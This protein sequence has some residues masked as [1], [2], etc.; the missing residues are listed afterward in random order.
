M[1]PTRI[2]LV[3]HGQTA[4]FMTGA[5]NALTEPGRDQ[6]SALGRYWAQRGF[7]PDVVLCGPQPRHRETLQLARAAAE[8]HGAPWPDPR[9]HPGFDEHDGPAVALAGLPALVERGEPLARRLAAGD[10]LDGRERARLFR[11][12]MVGWLQGEIDA[13]GTESFQA[14]RVRVGAAL[15]DALG[16]VE[17]GGTLAV[18]TSAGAVAA[19][20]GH[21]VGADDETVMELSW[22]VLNASLT[23]LRRYRNH[24]AAL[25]SF[26]GTPHLAP[27]LETFL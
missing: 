14:F 9:H 27:E 3:R 11:M 12:L 10:R 13:P 17:D 16:L 25:M 18:F 22:S 7:V 8:A 2:V 6:A 24:A 19:A 23:V 5:Y 21:V 26:N 20:T 1:P 4:G 15:G